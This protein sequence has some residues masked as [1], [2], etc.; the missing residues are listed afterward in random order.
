MLATMNLYRLVAFTA[1]ASLAG[2]G[3]GDPAEPGNDGPPQPGNY[4]GSITDVQSCDDVCAEQSLTCDGRHEWPQF[5]FGPVA[6]G[7]QG[8]YQRPEGASTSVELSCS[9]SPAD[10]TTLDGVVYGLTSYQCACIFDPGGLVDDVDEV[11]EFDGAYQG[12]FTLSEPATVTY[13]IDDNYSLTPNEWKV[14]IVP[15]SSVEEFLAGE[16]PLVYGAFDGTGPTSTSV[17]APAGDYALVVVCQNRSDP[18]TFNTFVTV[19]E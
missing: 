3:S 9:D 12:P 19:A 17:S 18:C 11:I 2:C 14:A 10:T 8:A 13:R 15:A 5:I 16:D 4:A 1:L 7:G 6:A